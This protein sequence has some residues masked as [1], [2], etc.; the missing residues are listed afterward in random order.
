MQ[1]DIFQTFLAKLE[2][3]CQKILVGSEIDYRRLIPNDK[4]DQVIYHCCYCAS[5]LICCHLLNVI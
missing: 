4:T 5:F 1:K 3:N 2:E